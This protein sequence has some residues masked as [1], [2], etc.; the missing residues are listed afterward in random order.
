MTK[1]IVHH[2]KVWDAL[3]GDFVVPP[4][5]GAAPSK[6][7][8][9]DIAGIGGEILPNTAEVIDA[10]QLDVYGRYFPNKNG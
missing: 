10:D 4:T 7:T 1:L 2:F 9:E 3:R 5:N 8:A 6:R